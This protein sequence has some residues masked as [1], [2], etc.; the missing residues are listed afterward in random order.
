LICYSR[1]KISELCHIV[2]KLPNN[3]DKYHLA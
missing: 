1:S 3:S 2:K